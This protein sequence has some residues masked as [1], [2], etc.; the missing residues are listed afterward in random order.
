MLEYWRA[1]FSSQEETESL[2]RLSNR[3]FNYFKCISKE[4]VKIVYIVKKLGV[5][6][7]GI[8]NGWCQPT[9]NQKSPLLLGFN[10]LF[11]GILL[12]LDD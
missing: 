5:S 4:K 8:S 12:L 7:D 2:K 6:I 9:K 3:F 1:F 10:K 11:D